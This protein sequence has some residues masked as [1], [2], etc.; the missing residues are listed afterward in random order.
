MNFHHDL[1]FGVGHKLQFRARMKTVQL[2]DTEIVFLQNF[3]TLGIENTVSYTYKVGLAAECCRVK[4]VIM[5]EYNS[6]L[7]W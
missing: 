6:N 7:N 5:T 3:V 2:K 1:K 4:I